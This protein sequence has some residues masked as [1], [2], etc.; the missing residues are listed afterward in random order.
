[1]THTHAHTQHYR[2]WGIHS[3]PSIGRDWFISLV[4]LSTERSGRGIQSVYGV[5]H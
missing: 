3:C 4:K 5:V 2:I 1:M